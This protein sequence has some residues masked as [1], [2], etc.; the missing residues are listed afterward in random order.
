MSV[1]I[2]HGANRLTLPVAGQAIHDVKRQLR[3]VLNVREA[4]TAVINGR[5]VSDEYLLNDG[6]VLEF[7][8]PVG[9]KG[10]NH[11]YWSEKELIEFFGPEPV[12]RMKR[13][14]MTTTPVPV[15]KGE[16]VISWSK[17]LFD[18]DHDPSNTL[19]IHVEIEKELVH[20]DGMTYPIDMPLAA[21]LK[22]L[23]DAKGELR[24]AQD[25]KNEYPQYIIDE[26][27]FRAINEGLKRHP[28]GLGEHIEGV[29]G[30]GYRWVPPT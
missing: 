24:S 21:I 22:C 13:A 5:E 6:D 17:W 14:G 29:K 4:A 8:F 7:V 10:G 3:D 28:S 25:M 16:E 18:S 2:T 1:E 20:V 15:M 9:R 12:E 23:I 11:D 26:S 19:N 27:L 30:R